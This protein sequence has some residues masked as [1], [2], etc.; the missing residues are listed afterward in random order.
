VSGEVAQKKTD[1]NGSV[2]CSNA[3]LSSP[4]FTTSEMDLPWAESASTTYD[5]RGNPHGRRAA[6]FGR[7]ARY[8]H[9]HWMFET[10]SISQF[11][12]AFPPGWGF[13]LPVVYSV[14]IFVVVALYPLCRWFAEVERRR[15]DAW[16]SHL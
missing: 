8:G 1:R 2:H 16:L 15:S 4:R 9:V 7:D 3:R 6:S 5:S 12:V 14:W 11:P 13:S 10:P